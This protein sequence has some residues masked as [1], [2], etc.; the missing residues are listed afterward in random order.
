AGLSGECFASVETLAKKC[1]GLGTRVVQKALRL[2]GQ[3]KV[4]T[5][6]GFDGPNGT[7]R[8]RLGF[9]VKKRI[10]E[11]AQGGANGDR[12]DAGGA[13]AD[14]RGAPM[15]VSNVHACAQTSQERL[16]STA[17]TTTQ[18]TGGDAAAARLTSAPPP[19]SFDPQKI[20]FAGIT[21]D[22]MARWE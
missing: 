9:R 1:G 11:G 10:R 19:L 22:D 4:L 12:V 21:S 20:A 18:G 16:N 8:Y 3:K 7:G 5:C 13:R 15:D 2:G 6:L 14:A 17:Q